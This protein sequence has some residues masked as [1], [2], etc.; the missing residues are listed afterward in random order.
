VTSPTESNYSF[1]PIGVIRS[2]YTEKFAVPRQPGLVTAAKATLEL[3]GDCN[4]EEIL[5]GIDEFSHLWLTFIFHE[6]A[7]EGWKPTVRPPRLGGN[8][9][10]GVFATRSP[11]RPNPLGLSVVKLESI[12]QASRKQGKQWL[13]H[14]SGI[15]LVNGTPILDIKPYVPYA[16]SISDATGGFAPAAPSTPRSVSFNNKASGRLADLSSQYPELETLICQVIAQQPQPAYLTPPKKDSAA[17]RIFGMTLYNLN[18]RWISTSNDYQVID[19]ET[20]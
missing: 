11:Y 18:I 1:K 2:P 5:R 13:L 4:R 6:V 19:I 12:E 14:L 8:H 16:D 15:D 3:C 9:R 20:V 10:L 17:D 7:N